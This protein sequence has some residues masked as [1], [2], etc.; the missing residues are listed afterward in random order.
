MWK[1][2]ENSDY[3]KFTSFEIGYRGHCYKQRLTM[4]SRRHYF[5]GALK[6]HEFKGTSTYFS[7]SNLYWVIDLLTGRDT[8]LNRTKK[9]GWWKSWEKVLHLITAFIT[10]TVEDRSRTLHASTQSRIE[11]QPPRTGESHLSTHIQSGIALRIIFGAVQESQI[12]TQHLA[13][14]HA[15]QT[16]PHRKHCSHLSWNAGSSAE[17]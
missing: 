5:V 14:V 4:W 11:K 7:M 8:N 15:L 10:P 9:I 3:I 6:W 12:L 2:R 16:E 13:S 17:H 1:Q